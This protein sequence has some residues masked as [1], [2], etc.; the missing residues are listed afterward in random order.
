[1][2]AKKY[3]T[4]EE[5]HLSPADSTAGGRVTPSFNVHVIAS[6]LFDVSI[7][8]IGLFSNEC[9]ERVYVIHPMHY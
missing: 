4:S 5:S 1:M 7:L 6:L 2:R 9:D 3:N 8:F